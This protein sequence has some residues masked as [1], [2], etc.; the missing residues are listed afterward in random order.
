MWIIHMNSSIVTDLFGEEGQ[1]NSDVGVHANL[2][3]IF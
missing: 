2:R 1:A 3:G